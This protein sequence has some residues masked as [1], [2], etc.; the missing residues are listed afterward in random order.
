VLL[1]IAQLKANAKKNYF[2]R[3]YNCQMGQ[4][5]PNT[6]LKTNAKKLFFSKIK[7]PEI[8]QKYLAASYGI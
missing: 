2:P 4:K 3:K 7:L 5:Y 1:K 6:H 8:G